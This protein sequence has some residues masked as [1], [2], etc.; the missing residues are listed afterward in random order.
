MLPGALAMPTA[1]RAVQVI[2]GSLCTRAALGW[3]G[4]VAV[5]V[6]MLVSIEMLPQVV[7]VLV[8]ARGGGRTGP[9]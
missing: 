7:L 4:Q 6:L 8:C 1:P 9:M 2:V 5:R 3:L